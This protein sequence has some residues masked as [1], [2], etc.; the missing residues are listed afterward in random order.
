MQRYKH[1]AVIGIDGMGGFNRLAPTPCMDKIFENGA[2][3]F[4]ALS[5]DPTIS[6]ENWGGMLIGCN[7]AVHRLTNGY[8]SAHPY[9]NNELPSL[10]KRIRE[11]NPEAYL[12]SVVNWNPINIGIAEDG[13]GVDKRTADNDTLVTEE[14]L[15][16]TKNKPV[17]LFVQLDEVDGAG[18]HF[19]YGTQGHLDRITEIDALVGKMYDEYVKAGITDDTL[20]ICIADHGGYGHGHGGWT[21]T[22][23]YIFLGVSGRGVKKGHIDYA[24]T[25]DISAIVLYALGIDIPEYSSSGYS[26]QVPVGIF[27]DYDR[28]YMKP[29]IKVPAPHRETEAFDA[30][31][32]LG[33]IFGDRIKL[34][35]FFDSSS[36]DETKNFIAGETGNVKFYSNGVR[37]ET[38]EFGATGAYRISGI[39]FSRSFSLSFWLLADADLDGRICVIGNKS[40]EN[41]KHQEK[42]FNILLRNHSVMVQLGCGDDD[43]DTVTAFGADGFSGWVNV[44]VSFDFENR[45]VRTVIDF[46]TVHTDTVD[47]KYLES[48]SEGGDF[49]IGDDVYLDFNKSRGLIF[50]MD[51]LIV[52]DGAV[53][54]KD[55]SLLNNYYGS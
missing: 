27:E 17:F 3:T 26:S 5:M 18:H 8:I 47:S 29:E 44:I 54:D 13:I 9:T 53:S 52:F 15:D 12:A 45:E 23:K 41:G 30:P 50:R 49:V 48:I 42:G 19:G 21:D 35:M 34:C 6:A 25:K 4:N 40:P 22:E 46:D 1:V 28:E 38:A 55:I 32:G 7:P 31:G 33:E 24:V 43:T 36:A 14:V 11:K 2:Y 10:F 37:G 20:F 51:D 16:C 39:D